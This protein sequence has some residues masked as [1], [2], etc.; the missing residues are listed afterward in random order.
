MTE[1]AEAAKQTNAQ[2]P[3][4]LAHRI[5]DVASDKKASDIVL[6][7]TA[8]ITTMADYFVIA[9][10]RSD[11]QVQALSQA[12]VDELRDEGIKPI[13]VEG[14]RSARWVLLDYGSVIVHLFAPEEREYYGLERLWSTA[15]QVV[16]LV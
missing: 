1:L 12:I 11:R 5:V 2:D 9:S 3:G 16:R 6:L 8:E 15:T 14:L 10:G 7:R 4:D 13:G